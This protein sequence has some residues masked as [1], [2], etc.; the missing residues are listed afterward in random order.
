M[1][2]KACASGK[3]EVLLVVVAQSDSLLYPR[4]V[5]L[6]PELLLR[7]VGDQREACLVPDLQEEGLY[8][9]S[10]PYPMLKV[11]PPT[12]FWTSLGHRCP[13]PHPPSGTCLHFDRAQISLLALLVHLHRTL[14]T[15]A[16]AL[17]YS[18]CLR[19]NA[20]S[21]YDTAGLELTT[22]TSLSKHDVGLLHHRRRV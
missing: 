11:L 16:L 20:C 13:P 22:P 3:Q 12:I 14:P 2:L 15:Q 17:S 5:E 4:L 19:K 6:T 18:Q 7:E 9:Q 21:R 1:P 10:G 8:R